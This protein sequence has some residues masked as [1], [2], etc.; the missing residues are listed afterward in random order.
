MYGTVEAFRTYAAARG[1]MKPTDTA[2]NAIVE[3]ALLRA[4]DYIRTRYVTQHYL[5][6]TDADM[7]AALTEATYIAAAYELETP[8]FWAK[9]YT[10]AQQKVLTE[11]AGVK[12]TVVGSG[13]NPNNM[14]PT[15]PA[16]EGLLFGYVSM[17][18]QPAIMVI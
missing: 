5:D 18:W 4:S 10:P 1:N 6:D 8:G 3:Q 15:S 16:I 12:W 14:L 13:A 7:L 17:G 9:V 2:S 11:V